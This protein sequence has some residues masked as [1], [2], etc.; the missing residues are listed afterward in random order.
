MIYFWFLILALLA[1]VLGTVGGFGSSVYFVPLAGFYFD[2][3]TVLGM[4]AVFHL[5]SNISKLSLF[6]AGIDR[7]LI[8]NLGL[9]SVI[10]VILGGLLSSKFSA[11][12]LEIL[13]GVFLVV[14]SIFLIVRSNFSIKP[15][16]RNSIVGG[17]LSG[18]TAGLL[19]SGGAIRGITMAAF[20]LDKKKFIATSAAIDLAVDFTRTLVYYQ[21]GYIDETALRYLPYLLVIGFIGSWLGKKVLHYLSE[22][23]FKSFALLLILGIG[24]V[25]LIRSFVN[26]PG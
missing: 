21:N 11:L 24:L 3:K 25:T 15:S 18:F 20:N 14:L 26:L 2:F 10:F 9:P 22:R 5:S 19:G 17:S 6:R 4:V 13:F 16:L 23:T 12:Y 8:L 1:E 7:Q